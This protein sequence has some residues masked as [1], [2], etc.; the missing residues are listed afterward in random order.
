MSDQAPATIENKTYTGMEERFSELHSRRKELEDELT[1][2]GS[3]RKLSELVL[4]AYKLSAEATHL[5]NLV[6]ARHRIEKAKADAR[7][8][9]ELEGKV[10]EKRVKNAVRD[11]DTVQHLKGFRVSTERLDKLCYGLVR[12]VEAE[13]KMQNNV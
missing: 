3:D 10:T 12:A 8:R 1:T 7:L 2:E 9:E 11:D 4:D 13:V 6:E 5:R